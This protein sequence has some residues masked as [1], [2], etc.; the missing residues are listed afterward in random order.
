MTSGEFQ[1]GSLRDVEII[2][3][4]IFEP[5]PVFPVVVLQKVLQ[6]GC[7]KAAVVLTKMACNC[8]QPLPGIL[9][10]ASQACSDSRSFSEIIG[11]YTLRPRTNPYFPVS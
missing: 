4:Q 10:D 2:F 11:E 8:V 7:V 1:E 6:L 5:L 9:H 3:H